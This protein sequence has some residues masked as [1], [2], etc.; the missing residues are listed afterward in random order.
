MRRSQAFPS[1]YV[2]KDDLEAPRL[3]VI[4]ELAEAMIK[5]DH[6]DERKTVMFFKDPE[7]KP[8]IMNTC[9]WMALEDA[10]GE[11]SD[12]W[13]G[14][15]VELY[16]NPDVMYAGKRVGGVR[17]RIPSS[18]QPSQNES[19][20]VDLL[21][22]AEAVDACDEVGIGKDTLIVCLKQKGHDGYNSGRDT[23]YVR[24]I[25]KNARERIAEK[26]PPTEEAITRA[27]EEDDIPFD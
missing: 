5:G 14:K 1:K 3:M 10:Y 23:A 13:I 21:S 12:D 24:E 15:P 4:L 22:F 20:G 8:L 17:V 19:F 9:N 2:G 7:S 25:I 27:M 26:A 11:E 16:V 6:G 18:G